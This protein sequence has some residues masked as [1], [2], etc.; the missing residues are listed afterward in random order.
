LPGLGPGADPG[1]ELGDDLLGDPGV[2]VRACGIGGARHGGLLET[3]CG[4]KERRRGLRAAAALWS[5]GPDQ[6]VSALDLHQGGVDRS[7]EAGIVELDREVVAV[8]LALA[9]PGGAELGLAGEDPEVGGL[10]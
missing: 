4:K 9:L 2:D 5:A 7:R 6:A 8:L 1:F 3:E 10:V